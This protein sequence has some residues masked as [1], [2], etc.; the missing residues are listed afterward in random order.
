MSRAQN[1]TASMDRS[2]AELDNDWKPNGRRPQ[3]SEI[4]QL[5]HLEPRKTADARL[6]R[7]KQ[8][9]NSQA[10]ELEALERRIREM[11]ERLKRNHPAGAA[12]A[13]PA[14]QAGQG[15]PAPV[16]KDLPQRASR[17]GTAKAQQQAPIHGG[18]MPPT[19]TASEGEYEL[20]PEPHYHNNM[21]SSTSIYNDSESG[22]ETRSFADMVYGFR[23]EELPLRAHPD[24]EPNPA[25]HADAP[26]A[27]DYGTANRAQTYI[28]QPNTTGAVA[29]TS[30]PTRHFSTTKNTLRKTAWIQTYP[31]IITAHGQTEQTIDTLV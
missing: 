14:A 28:P 31:T 22:L 13:R 23:V 10:S 16:Q 18:A 25:A 12:G 15:A 6:T 30:S 26:M 29:T 27:Q 21:S 11:E 3:S 17:P 8:E 20:V 24:L 9:V 7:R 5:L 4:S 19:P 2:D 1:T